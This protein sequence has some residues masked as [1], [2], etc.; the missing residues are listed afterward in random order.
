MSVMNN[1]TYGLFV[2]TT[3]TNKHNG[4]IINTLMQVTSTPNQISVT[5]NKSN[6]TTK[7]IQESGVFNV[8][9][10]DTTTNFDLI[11]R[12]GFSSGENTDKFLGFENFKIAE[13]GISYITESTNSVICAKVT[14]KIDLGTHITFIADVVEMKE[15]GSNE[16]LT[17]AFYHKNIKPKAEVK[18]GVYVC[19]IC[20]YVYEGETLPDDFICPICK[21]GAQDFEYREPIKAEPKQRQFY[22]P[23]CDR[24]EKS[25]FEISAC[26]ICGSSMIEVEV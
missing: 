6:K 22:C 25:L 24:I 16:S 7:I 2:I 13:N 11:K 20:G 14:K 12:F 3:K 1:I 9:I 8:S 17:Y 15:L 4:C 18:K 19:K 26:S 10:L 21:H 23:N 5:L